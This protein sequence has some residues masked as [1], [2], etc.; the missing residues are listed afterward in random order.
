MM[1]AIEDSNALIM[2]LGAFE[3]APN[4]LDASSATA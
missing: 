1:R 3:I 2:T 4:M